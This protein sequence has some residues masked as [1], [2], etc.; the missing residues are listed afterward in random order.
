MKKSFLIFAV[1]MLSLAQSALAETSTVKPFGVVIVSKELQIE[2][3]RATL[4][5]HRNSM[6]GG[7]TFEKSVNATVK[8]QSPTEYVVSIPGSKVST[9][10]SF[11]GFDNCTYRVHVAT[12]ENGVANTLV[13]YESNHGAINIALFISDELTA[14]L[15]RRLHYSELIKDNSKDGGAYLKLQQ[16]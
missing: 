9:R 12:N 3:V 16:K 2:A 6:I 15:Q 13:A 1:S 8:V 14:T 5:C 4:Y 11:Q 7:D 10:R